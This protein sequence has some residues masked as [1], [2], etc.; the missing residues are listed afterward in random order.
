MNS[1]KSQIKLVLSASC[2]TSLYL[3]C[4]GYHFLCLPRDLYQNAPLT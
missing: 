2:A 4:T 3:N 1:E